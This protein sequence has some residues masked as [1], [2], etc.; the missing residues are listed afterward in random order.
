M[1]ADK[2]VANLW[3]KV[4][5]LSVSELFQTGFPFSVLISRSTV[6]RLAHFLH[7]HC[8][9]ELHN[10][11][12][13]ARIPERFHVNISNKDKKRLSLRRGV[14]TSSSVSHRT[15]SL[16]QDGVRHRMV[17]SRSLSATQHAE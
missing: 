15:R 4:S 10:R 17:T 13:L 8:I 11:V 3:H 16:E 7:G 5:E 14:T 2:I 12:C 1:I 6:P 9:T